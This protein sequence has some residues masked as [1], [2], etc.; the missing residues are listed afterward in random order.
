MVAGGLPAFQVFLDDGTG[1]FPYDVSAY[2]RLQEGYTGTRGRGD[3]LAEVEAGGLNL[4]FD[5]TD[6]RFSLGS[7]LIAS[8]S[9]IK[10]DRRVRVRL[11]PGGN[12]IGSAD[13]ASFEGSIGGWAFNTLLGA[14]TAGTSLAQSATRAT[15]GVDS[16]LITWST[17]AT[18]NYAGVS[19]PTVVGQTYTFS[20]D[21]YVPTGSPNVKLLA[22]FIGSSAFVTTK[23]AWVRASVTFT[24]TAATTFVGVD[25]LTSTAGQT[26]YVDSAAVNLGSVA[27]PFVAGGLT[28]NRFTQH[29]QSWPVEWP[30][31][32]DGFAI[33]NIGATDVQAKLESDRHPLRSV[34][35]EEIMVDLPAAYYMMAEAA[36]SSSAADSSGNQRGALTMAGTGADVVF[37]TAVGPTTDGLT[38]AT[39]A[40]G[41][42][43]TSTAFGLWS[44]YVVAFSTSTVAAATLVSIDTGSFIGASCS[45]DGSGHLVVDTIWTSA[46]PVTDGA[47]HVIEQIA[48]GGNKVIFLDGVQVSS[49]PG[50]G[51]TGGTLNI[52]AGFVGTMAHVAG[53]PTGGVP[54][55]ARPPQHAAA[56]LTGFAGESGTAR[57]TRLAGYANVPVG[58][59]DTSLT[60]VAFE[61]TT[62]KS[63]AEELRNVADAEVGLV[64]IDGSGNLTFQNRNRAV[65]KLVPDVTIDANFLADGTRFECDM[66]GVLNYFEVT[67]A[68]TSVTQVVR[69]TTSEVANQHGRYKG[70]K[71]Y[72][73]QTDQE[74]LDRG[75]WIVSTHAEPQPRVGSL[76]VDV[77][78]M[79]AAQQAAMLT[80]EPNSWLRITG[81]PG[82]TPGS[83]TADFIVQG[84]SDALNSAAWAMTL[85]AANKAVAAPTPWILGDLTWSLL[86]STT[87][88]YV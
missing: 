79:T 49:T 17:T 11:T 60:N 62:G 16:L 15:D 64:F 85:N 63:V 24:A 57:L 22:A 84:F 73:V 69:N 36:G 31:A 9:P 87:V 88:P 10:V 6:G 29:V 8:P 80:L 86:G 19:V 20:A 45:I 30:S 72:L 71:T 12:L 32:D 82:Q 78:T 53:W 51:G 21:V 83:T 13:A 76:V 65:S 27:L 38:A 54:V 46:A 43:L 81:L 47:L 55:V 42:Y 68:G 56:M 61:D 3:E 14:R 28:V 26:C 25:Q 41:K 34:I 7:T 23:D 59:L 70:S 2:A 52:G 33:A 74:A 48:T 39:F 50:G 44:G 40:G 18:G 67:A 75:N 37:G 77:L 4:A 5:N 35:E 1:T 58:T 66:Q